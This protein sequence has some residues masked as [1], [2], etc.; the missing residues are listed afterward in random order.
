MHKLDA[1]KSP[2]SQGLVLSSNLDNHTVDWLCFSEK[3]CMKIIVTEKS[4]KCTHQ[5]PWEKMW[6]KKTNKQKQNKKQ[7]KT[8][9]KTKTKTN[10]KN[11][12]KNKQTKNKT[13][14]KTKQNKTKQKKSSHVFSS[15]F[16]NFVRTL[17]QNGV[18]WPFQ[19]L[20][21]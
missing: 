14:Q 7:N 21:Y 2:S 8:K 12:Q 20:V 17:D 19:P 15:N 18:Y 6:S 13:N 9:T 16:D 5:I 11:K 4:N 1:Q 3:S 10:P